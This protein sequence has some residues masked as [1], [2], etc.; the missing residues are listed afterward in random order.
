LE[1]A[2][3]GEPFHAAAAQHEGERCVPLHVACPLA[4]RVKVRVT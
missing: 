3:V 2:D 4:R 1:H